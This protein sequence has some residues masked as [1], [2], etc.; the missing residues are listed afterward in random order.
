MKKTP[1]IPITSKYFKYTNAVN[2]DIRKRFEE[3][4][5]QRRL[6]SEEDRRFIEKLG[7]PGGE[8]DRRT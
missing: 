7:L 8:D 2:T 6:E 1:T 3:E 4:E 5:K